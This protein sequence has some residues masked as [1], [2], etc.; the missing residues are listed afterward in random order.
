MKLKAHWRQFDTR[1]SPDSIVLAP[2]FKEKPDL[3]IPPS[4]S[5]IVQ[6]R[7]AEIVVSE[8]LAG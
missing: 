7:A 8:R 4:K 3:W 1:K 6:I 5:C 2:G